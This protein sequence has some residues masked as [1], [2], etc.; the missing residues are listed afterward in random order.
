MHGGT[1]P[2]ILE[3]WQQ[4]GRTEPDPEVRSTWGAF[5]LLFAELAGRTEAWKKALEGWNMRPSQVVEEWRNEG[6]VEGQLATRREDLLAL[7]EERF[8]AL[9]DGLLQRIQAT[10]DVERLKAAL[11]QVLHLHTA[12]DLQL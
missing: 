1:E 6:R 5:A 10:T 8:G 11:R 12:K 7:L 3:Q 9:P 4:V 2:G